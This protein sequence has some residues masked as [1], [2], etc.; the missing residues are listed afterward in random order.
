[1]SVSHAETTD[2]KLNRANEI[3]TDS[4]TRMPADR[5]TPDVYVPD[6]E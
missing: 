3:L 5:I 6:E 2:K 4:F 1:M